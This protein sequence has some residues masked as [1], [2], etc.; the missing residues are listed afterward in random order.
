MILLHDLLGCFQNLGCGLG[1]KGCCMLIQ[2]Q[3]LRFLQSCHQE[4]QRLPLTAG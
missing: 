4:G 1:V 2:K 3:K